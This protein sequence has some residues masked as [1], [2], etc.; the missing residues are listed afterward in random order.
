M[1]VAAN[2]LFAAGYLAGLGAIWAGLEMLVFG[3]EDAGRSVLVIALG[4][5]I[6]SALAAIGPRR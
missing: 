4:F 3:G 6:W 5:M 1:R 2:A